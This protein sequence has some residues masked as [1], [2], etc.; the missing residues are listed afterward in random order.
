VGNRTVMVYLNQ[1]VDIATS[2][3]IGTSKAGGPARSIRLVRS[4]GSAC[5]PLITRSP[6]GR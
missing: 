3:G 2:R 6:I 5:N 4:V 1:S